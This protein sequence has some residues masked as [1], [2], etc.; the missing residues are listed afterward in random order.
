MHISGKNWLFF[1][2]DRLLRFGHSLQERVIPL[3]AVQVITQSAAGFYQT[4]HIAVRP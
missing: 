1:V 2:A 4:S 3:T